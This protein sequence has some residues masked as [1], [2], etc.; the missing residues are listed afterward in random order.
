[1]KN[2]F[3]TLIITIIFTQISQ[4]FA[5]DFCKSPLCWRC[6]EDASICQQCKPSYIL[7]NNNCVSCT[8]YYTDCLK[9]SG[10]SCT[11]CKEGFFPSSNGC[12]PRN[13]Q[14]ADER[15]ADCLLCVPGYTYSDRKCVPGACP[16]AN[17]AQC[18]RDGCITCKKG[19]AFFGPEC[20]PGSCAELTPHCSECDPK[21]C[22]GCEKGYYFQNKTCFP[23][24]NL[25]VNS[26]AC[27]QWRIEECQTGFTFDKDGYYG[28]NCVSKNCDVSGKLQCKVCAAHFNYDNITRLCSAGECAEPNCARCG[29]EGCNDCYLGYTLFQG[30]CQKG[31]CS[32]FY[33]NCAKC[34]KSGC[35][36]CNS[37]ST[38]F[39]NQC[40]IGDC[41]TFYPNCDSC[42][43]NKCWSCKSGYNFRDN[44]DTCIDVNYQPLSQRILAFF[45]LFIG[46]FILCGC[47][48]CCGRSRKGATSPTTTTATHYTQYYEPRKPKAYLVVEL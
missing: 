33:P 16:Q 28:Q 9:C 17:C 3:L 26:S 32:D 5:D 2:L 40:K 47:L 4:S 21:G 7:D 20:K 38:M 11:S 29:S 10:T 8:E 45:Q 13:C 35:T 44:G 34:D 46:F 18:G 37:D 48:I 25:Y 15:R 30:E 6:S 42:D 36:K 1:M 31:T 24:S 19:F 12:Y 41:S 22:T 23:C 14:S 43:E 39:G 27:S